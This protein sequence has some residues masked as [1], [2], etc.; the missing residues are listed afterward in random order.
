MR[1]RC[2]VLYGLAMLRECEEGARSL[3]LRMCLDSRSWRCYRIVFVSLGS[4]DGVAS[5]FQ[6]MIM[7]NHIDEMEVAT[8]TR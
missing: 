1:V 3:A 4:H 5:G 2:V 6:A 7:A 8:V